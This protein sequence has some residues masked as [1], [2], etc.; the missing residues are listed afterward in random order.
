[1]IETEDNSR[2]DSSSR[3]PAH[4]LR[5]LL[6]IRLLAGRED[7]IWRGRLSSS[8]LSTAVAAFALDRLNRDAHRD[9]V[10]RALHWLVHNVN[11]DGGWGDTIDSP[12]NLSATLISWA[13]LEGTENDSPEPPG[14]R[15]NASALLRCQAIE[16]GRTWI[17]RT[18]GS[19]DPHSLAKSV[20]AA[21]GDDR[22]FSVPILAFCALAGR[23]G[24]G[25]DAWKK[26]P[27][28]PFELAS[29][30]RRFF[31]AVRMQVVSYAI[32]ALIAIGMVR[33]IL[34]PSRNPVTRGLRNV[35]SDC[36][37]RRLLAMQPEGGGFLEAAPLTGFV[38]AS[39]AGAGLSDHPV[40]RRAAGFLQT[41][42]R[43]DGSWPID[44][45]LAMWVTTGA[46]S[47]LAAADPDSRFWLADERA[48]VRRWIV[49]HQQR[50][51]HPFTGSPPGGWGWSDRSGSVPDADDTAG[52][53][54]ALRALMPIPRESGDD[55]ESVL[56]SARAGI[57]WLLGIQNRDGG[58]PTFC[59]GWG[60]LPFDRSCPDLTA[61]AIRAFDAWI[62]HVPRDWA[63]RMVRSRAKAVRFLCESQK[64]DGS[65]ISLWFGNQ[66]AP[67]FANPTHGT[68]MVLLALYS[69]ERDP[70]ERASRQKALAW[71]LAAQDAGG[72]WGG[73]PGCEP[74][75]EETAWALAALRT[76]TDESPDRAAEFDRACR[77]GLNWLATAWSGELPVRP[78]PVGLY[79]ARLW[80]SEALYPLVFSLSAAA[81]TRFT[82]RGD[83]SP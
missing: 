82:W 79:F 59:R 33:H 51:A 57:G 3:D 12:S 47:A 13:A 15:H 80:Y 36:V 5:E 61:H 11:A 8:A 2:A 9:A 76:Q 72:G 81:K 73:A 37:M 16:R 67:N 7:G 68:S 46:A 35:L 17:E 50:C 26:V 44:T 41:T 21:Y 38:A 19:L 55:A 77:R 25:T 30:P 63:K 40:A 42:Q 27:Q 43:A 39:L 18:I 56:Q 29:L 74:T 6:V 75:V 45:D 65:W 62:E 24:T 71:L 10:R 4:T 31:S 78:S 60:R 28:L 53:L 69:P 49:S 23:M 83:P 20:L 52:A 22:T 58:F 66:S 34:C 64:S 48:N 14:A 70:F 54:L 32:P 1:M